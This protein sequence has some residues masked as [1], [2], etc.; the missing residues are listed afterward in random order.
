MGFYIAFNRS[1]RAFCYAVRY[2]RVDSSIGGQHAEVYGIRAVW[3]L[4]GDSG[5]G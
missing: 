3:R 4:E 1:L 5:G 2:V